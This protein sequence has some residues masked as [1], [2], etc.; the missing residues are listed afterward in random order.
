MSSMVQNAMRLHFIVIGTVVSIVL[1]LITVH[2][3]TQYAPYRYNHKVMANIATFD[4]INRTNS[5]LIVYVYYENGPHHANFAYFL[6]HALHTAADFVLVING[7]ISQEIDDMLPYTMN[8]VRIIKKNNTCFDFGSYSIALTQL[9]PNNY[10]RYI[11][12]NASVRGPFVPMYVNACWSNI[13]TDRLNH[14]IKLVGTTFNC[15]GLDPTQRNP[16]I[17][18]ML[19]AVDD[20]GLHILLSMFRCYTDKYK[21]IREVETQLANK[22]RSA[23]YSVDVLMASYHTNKDYYDQCNHNDVYG[24]DKGYFGT[25]INPYEVVFI[26]TN[27]HVDTKTLDVYTWIMDSRNYSSFDYC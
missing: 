7:D 26:K 13:F 4:K 10:K 27:N 16:H 2:T 6:R 15:F 17:Q 20:V 24:F 14:K 9:P 21:S 12:L 19:L 8:N 23:G 5:V 3:K 11:L 25:Y 1:Y 22:I 18:S